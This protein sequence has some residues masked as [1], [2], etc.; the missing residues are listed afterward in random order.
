MKAPAPTK[1]TT[2]KPTKK[3]IGQFASEAELLAEKNRRFQ[4]VFG[5]VDWKKARE[6]GLIS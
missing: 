6:D 3:P 5:N 4:Q 2:A 1:L